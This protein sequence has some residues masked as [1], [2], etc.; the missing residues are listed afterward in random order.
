MAGI[1]IVEDEPEI[2]AALECDLR[3]EGYD[4][5]VVRDGQSAGLRGR[6]PGWDLILLDIMLPKKDGFEVCQAKDLRAFSGWKERRNGTGPLE[7]AGRLSNQPPGC[8]FF[9]ADMTA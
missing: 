9:P 5:E 7:P 1:L 2:G 4:V 8:G 3:L 6:E